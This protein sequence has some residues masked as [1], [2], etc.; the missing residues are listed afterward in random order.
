MDTSLYVAMSGAKQA[1]LAQ[2]VNSHNLANAN[3]SG[4]KADLSQFRS[5]PVYGAGHPSNVY[6]MAERPGIDFNHGTMQ[7]TGR[8]LDV[9]INGDGWLAIQAE[10]GTE[11]YTRA[12]D[13]RITP[14]GLLTTGTGLPVMGGGGPVTMPEAQKIEIGSDGTISII[15][16][17]D[18]AATLSVI[19]RIKLVNPDLAD[20][21]KGK[22]GLF[23]LKNGADADPSAQVRLVSGS[24]E[25]SNVSVVSSMVSMIELARNFELQ[26]KM[27]K[28]VS[29]NEA[30]SAQLM[31]LS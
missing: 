28:T 14:N 17:G 21:E 23:R 7:S 11:A 24:V 22:D 10:D 16:L 9:S 29:E 4:F 1:M 13:L 31:R 30:T 6:A 26:V 25:G 19:D 5:M 20:I 3:T 18:S 8:E 2:A 15:P 12:G 27:M